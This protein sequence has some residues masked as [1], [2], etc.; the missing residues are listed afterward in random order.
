MGSSVL[1]SI[2]AAAQGI[3]HLVPSLPS[4]SALAHSVLSLIALFVLGGCSLPCDSSGIQLLVESGWTEWRITPR[5]TASS[6]WGGTVLLDV[7]ILETL[8]T[9]V[10]AR[11]VQPDITPVASASG[12]EEVLALS[13]PDPD[14]RTLGS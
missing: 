4:R 5:V 9:I 14:S 1:T 10:S 12:G 3:P 8:E 7:F 11:V 13:D 6:W 2:W